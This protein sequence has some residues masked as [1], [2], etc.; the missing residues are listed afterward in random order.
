LDSSE[1]QTSLRVRREQKRFDS[2]WLGLELWKRLELDRFF[3]QTVDEH[4]A[5]V[6]WSR[7]AAVLAINRYVRLAVS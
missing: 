2:C 6:P 4:Q 3:E 5:D 1:T 7:V